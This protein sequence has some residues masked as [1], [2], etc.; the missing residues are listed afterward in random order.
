M[1]KTMIKKFNYIE[2]NL[3]LDERLSRVTS[4]I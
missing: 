1:L 4:N 3:N 2:Y